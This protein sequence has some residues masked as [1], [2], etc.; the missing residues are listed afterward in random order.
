MRNILLSLAMSTM[1][2]LTCPAQQ[3][4]PTAASDKVTAPEFDGSSWWSYVKVLA[5]DDMEGRETGSAAL[6]RAEAYVVQQLR[7]DG[8][9]PAGADGFYQPIAFESRQIV[10]SASSLALLN[11]KEVEPLS[12]SNDAFFSTRVDLAPSVQAP[13]VFAGYGLSVPEKDYDDFAGLDLKG[14]VAVIVSGAPAEIPGALASHY[15]SPGERWKELRKA[16]A[17]GTIIILNPASM[18]IPWSR[19]SMNR[20]HPSMSLSGS[21]FD[22]TAG[23]K[24][25]VIFN[26]ARASKLFE[27]SGHSL[28]EIMDLA[29][30][31]KPLPR[32]PLALSI[33]AQAEVNKKTLE[34]SNVIAR[35]PGSDAKF[36][37]ESVVL[38]AHIDHIGIGEPI[39]GDR[40]YNGAMDNAAGSA[41]LLDVAASLRK[42]K[43]RPRRSILFVFFTGE[44]KGLL[45]S[46][47][48]TAH[49]TVPPDSMVANINIDMFLPIVPLKVLTIYG[50]AESSLGE[51]AAETAQ[52]LGVR[53]QPDPEPQR[54][55]FIRSDQYN[56]IR[57]GIPAVAMGVGFDPGTPEQ[58]IFKDWLTMRYHA[59]SDDLNQPVDLG[60]AAKYEEIIRNLMLRVA[61]SPGRPQWN[62]GSFF[63]R[64]AGMGAGGF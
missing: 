11:G 17:I 57:H 26:P 37:N 50:L 8:L 23:E 12:F 63:R 33:R 16:G 53:S 49:P 56:F 43:E 64:Y 31:G 9:E 30:A 27:G 14:K 20:T 46:K 41:I 22:E 3:T 38:S 28:Q 4:Q 45:G 36:Q 1:L 18:D 39:K 32:F 35:L 51:V 7:A 5:A 47:Y 48:F 6:K 55:A 42:S 15:Q 13:L 60:A 21:E 61:T 58:Q 25:A 59:P 19:I 34:S 52:S 44:E 24:L 62:T 10:E 40:I 54:N 29:K 2:V